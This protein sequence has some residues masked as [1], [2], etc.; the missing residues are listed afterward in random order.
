M[1]TIRR[2]SKLLNIDLEKGS[3]L[4]WFL[5]YREGVASSNNLTHDQLAAEL[6]LVDVTPYV[7]EMTITPIKCPN[8]TVPVVP[9]V[10]STVTGEITTDALELGVIR[11]VILSSMS[12]AWTF[13][14]ATYV[15]E[16]VVDA[17]DKMRVT[18]GR[19]NCYSAEGL[20]I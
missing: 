18:N 11:L 16:I 2:Q 5:E 10:L 19:V 1:A 4:R 8:D 7:I 13:T 3:T 17:T 6:D 12:E 15:L 20:P 9:I 14:E